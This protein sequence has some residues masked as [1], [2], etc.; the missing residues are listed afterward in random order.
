VKPFYRYRD[1]A[2]KVELYSQIHS[3]NF[4]MYTRVF[5]V[6]SEDSIGSVR[7]EFAHTRCG[8]I[9]RRDEDIRC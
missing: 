5:T 3:W 1:E 7:I 9:F 8:G 2:V 6:H 4:N